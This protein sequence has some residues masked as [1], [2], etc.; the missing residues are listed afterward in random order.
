MPAEALVPDAYAQWR[1]L[2]QEAMLFIIQRLSDARL[3]TKLIEQMDL[4]STTPI[5]VRLLRFIAKTPG[6]QKLG[7]VLARNRHLQPSL[8]KAL[9]ELENSISDV[10][11]ADIRA[12]IFEQLGERLQ[13]C[14]I[15]IEPEI[16]SEASVSAV[17]RFIWTNPDTHERERGVF[18]VLKPHVPAY[19]AEDLEFCSN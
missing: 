5:E 9:S 1:P 18:K 13:S 15:E 7:Q 12:M 2:F 4:P 6:L 8:R 14:G 3:A 16:A 19:F 17:M 11:S 10:T